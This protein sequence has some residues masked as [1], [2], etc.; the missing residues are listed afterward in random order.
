M[1]ILWKVFAYF[2]AV[3]FTVIPLAAIFFLAR[4]KFPFCGVDKVF[5]L[6]ICRVFA[7]AEFMGASLCVITLPP[8]RLF[9][10]FD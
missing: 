7:V 4:S 9:A 6:R 1:P 3:A 2:G 5:H 10:L 8:P